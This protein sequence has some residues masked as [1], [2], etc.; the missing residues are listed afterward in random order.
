M[1]LPAA[2]EFMLREALGD[3]WAAGVSDD[4]DAQNV[5]LCADD[6]FEALRKN[7][8]SLLLPNKSGGAFGTKRGADAG[9]EAMRALA[10]LDRTRVSDRGHRLRFAGEL[11]ERRTGGGDGGGGGGAREASAFRDKLIGS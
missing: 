1:A 6:A 9:R 5:S 2:V 4:F 3:L 7:R 8:A 10:R 11:S